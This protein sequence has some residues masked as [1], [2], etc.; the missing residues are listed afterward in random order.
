MR[1]PIKDSIIGKA[2][3]TWF[4]GMPLGTLAG[5]AGEGY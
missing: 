5:A 2:P 4:A 3:L 1:G